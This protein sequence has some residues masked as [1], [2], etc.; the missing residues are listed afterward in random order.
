MRNGYLNDKY[1]FQ[2]QPASRWGHLVM[3]LLPPPLRLEWDHYARHL[4]KPK[5]EKN[6]LLDVGCGNGEFLSR[7]KWQGWDA[8][9]IDFDEQ[10]LSHARENGIS[11]THGA[12]EPEKFKPESFDAIT[13]NQVIEHMHEPIEF[14][15]TLYS[16]LKPGGILWLGTPNM[17]SDSHRHFGRDWYCLH[18]PQHLFIFSAKSLVHSMQATGFTNVKIA[19]RGY[20][21]SHIYKASKKMRESREVGSLPFFNDVSD[22]RFGVSRQIILETLVW[23]RPERGSDLV[24][25]GRKA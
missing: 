6:K 10:A 19:P 12:V 25:M 5:S 24:A 9:G 22:V 2:M 20:M 21:E 14:L 8:Y 1:G 7:A 17:D 4:P 11:V 18:P 15:K 13:S 23:L 16:W 3:H